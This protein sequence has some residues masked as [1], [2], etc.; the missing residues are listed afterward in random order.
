MS[1]SMPGYPQGLWE[2]TAGSLG[3]TLATSATQEIAC[4]CLQT[5][6]LSGCTLATLGYRLATLGCS[7][8]T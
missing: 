1:A 7:A 6:G 3:C 8:A 4:C 2:S 5:V